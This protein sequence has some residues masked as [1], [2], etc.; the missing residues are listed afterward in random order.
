MKLKI[1]VSL[2][3]YLLVLLIEECA[4][5]IHRCCKII[6]FG[7]LEV[8]PGQ[9]LN[10]EVRLTHELIDMQ[11]VTRLLVRNGVISPPPSEMDMMNDKF[12]KVEKYMKY[13][14]EIGVLVDD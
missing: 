6:R 12:E 11:A 2:P 8:Q 5:I 13:S 9:G 4:E 3:V 10:N 14:R 1:K 7:L